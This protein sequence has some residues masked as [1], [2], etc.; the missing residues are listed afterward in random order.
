MVTIKPIAQTHTEN[1]VG[2]ENLMFNLPSNM[3]NSKLKMSYIRGF[4]IHKF[5]GQ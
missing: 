1:V 5:R 2:Q 3:Y 4:A